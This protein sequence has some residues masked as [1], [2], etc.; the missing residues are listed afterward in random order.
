MLWKAMIY[1]I[2][3]QSELLYVTCAERERECEK[4]RKNL[5][6]DQISSFYSLWTSFHGWWPQAYDFV[7]CNDIISQA[8][9]IFFCIFLLLGLLFPICIPLH[10]AYI[11]MNNCILQYHKHTIPINFAG[12]ASWA[13]LIYELSER[14]SLWL[15]LLFI[16]SY[17]I[18]TT[19]MKLWKEKQ[20][21]LDDYA[22]CSYQR[23]I[24][25]LI[26]RIQFVNSNFV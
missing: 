20:N 6:S 18:F 4:N 8:H 13:E 17:I 7:H 10:L 22:S 23:F 3:Q 19:Y 24:H 16:Q 5:Q 11:H 2:A 26:L 14:P 25:R 12:I 21:N 1:G 15:R 9:T